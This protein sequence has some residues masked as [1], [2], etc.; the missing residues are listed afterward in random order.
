M[1]RFLLASQND[2]HSH[3]SYLSYWKSSHATPSEMGELGH[4][5]LL[6]RPT[7]YTA[8]M[9]NFGKS[10]TYPFPVTP[11]K[12]PQYLF[13]KRSSTIS[14]PFQNLVGQMHSDSQHFRHFR[15]P[16][17]YQHRVTRIRCAQCGHCLIQCHVVTLKAYRP[18]LKT[19]RATRQDGRKDHLAHR[20]IAHTYH[21]KSKH[22]LRLFT[23]GHT[24]SIDIVC[25]YIS[26][27]KSRSKYLAAFSLAE[28]K[29]S[30]LSPPIPNNRHVQ[31]SSNSKISR[32]VAFIL[33]S[34]IP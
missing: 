7:L 32:S 21:S 11:S 8:Q 19:P 31:H 1:V 24:R 20:M 27:H 6:P 30:T 33:P 2:L 34:P 18:C 26:H 28:N 14:K 17:M 15:K 5:T 23:Y 10:T 13:S 3:S 4:H 22:S 9:S 16:L 29:R 12:M 25:P